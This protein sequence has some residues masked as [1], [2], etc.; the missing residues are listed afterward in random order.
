MDAVKKY[1]P[2]LAAAVKGW[3]ASDSNTVSAG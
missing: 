1:G 2:I 3:R